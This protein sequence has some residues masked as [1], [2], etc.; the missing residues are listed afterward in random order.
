MKIITSC[1]YGGRDLI[2]IHDLDKIMNHYK[3]LDDN[4]DLDILN[5]TY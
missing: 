3:L 1:I 5:K 2:R 4:W